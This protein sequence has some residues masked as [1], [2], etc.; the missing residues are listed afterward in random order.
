MRR[1]CSVAA[2]L[3]SLLLLTACG[4]GS[5]TTSSSFT[6]SAVVSTPTTT[7]NSTSS[8]STGTTST[9]GTGSTG[10][11]STGTTGTTGS[12]GSASNNS[13]SLLP[14]IPST[15][16]VF[17]AIQNTTNAWSDCSDCAGGTVTSAYSTTPFL[18]TPSLSGSSRQFFVGGP[19]WA[20][21][22]WIHKVGA[23]NQASHFLWDFYVYF[24]AASASGVWSA[25]YDFW[26]SIGG[27]KLMMGTQ[28]VFGT[29][30]WDVWDSRNNR[31]VNTSIACPRFSAG[32]WHHLEL[33]AE[34]ISPT[35]YRFNTLF[36][37]AQ[38]FTINRVFDT[39]PTDWSDDM[40]VQWQ[41]D[42]NGNGT[43]L[44][45][46]VDRVKLTVW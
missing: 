30:E 25:E 35:Q 36:V 19:A 37:D 17:D 8:G 22:L 7:P 6:P 4:G 14:S 29:N 31:W 21:A 11:A 41:L 23:Q 40:G 28:C 1:L 27:Q 10:T 5:S 13:S 46:W 12:T 44:T 38:P 3:P 26:Q 32:A 42:Q 43:A 15:A 9:S 34:R 24:D 18:A 20:S 45:E 16:T 39:E 33:Y 2:L